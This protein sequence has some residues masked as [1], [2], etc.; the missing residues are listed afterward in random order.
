MGVLVKEKARNVCRKLENPF[1][2]K[3]L[4]GSA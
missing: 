1:A 3:E 4:F 2:R